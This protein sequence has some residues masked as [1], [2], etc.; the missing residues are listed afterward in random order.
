MV[1]FHVIPG[2]Q[3]F[4]FHNIAPISEVKLSIPKG[5][6]SVT[7]YI[8]STDVVLAALTISTL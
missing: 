2:F 4:P 1:L 5:L 6:N 7:V 3:V 8:I